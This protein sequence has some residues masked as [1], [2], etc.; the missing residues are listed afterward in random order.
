MCLFGYDFFLAIF[1]DICL[2]SVSLSP[3]SWLC[4]ARPGDLATDRLLVHLSTGNR[5]IIESCVIRS[6]NS[7][8]HRTLHSV[9]TLTPA[10]KTN[11]H[12]FQFYRKCPQHK[13]NFPSRHV[14]VMCR[15]CFHSICS[16]G[17]M[18]QV[19][20]STQKLH[21]LPKVSQQTQR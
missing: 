1:A 8:R 3:V 18:L 15:G 10:L 16:R 7:P 13:H 6:R 20:R 4:M 12:R 9:R 19:S 17:I 2:C 5:Q 14:D 11:L 21:S